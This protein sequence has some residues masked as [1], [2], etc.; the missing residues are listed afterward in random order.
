MSVRREK[1]RAET[2]QVSLFP[3]LAVLLCTMGILIMLL[4]L[5]GQ[6]T[7]ERRELAGQASENAPE[8]KSAWEERLFDFPQTTDSTPEDRTEKETTPYERADETE[9][10]ISVPSPVAAGQESTEKPTAEEQRYRETR[11]AF[12]DLDI[13]GLR[14]EVE[15]AV[16]FR[17]ELQQVYDR[18][19]ESLKAAR[20]TLSQ[21]EAQIARQVEHLAD[22]EN[23]LRAL[24]EENTGDTE[25]TN[26]AIEEKKSAIAALN[27]E[28][29]E[30]KKKVERQ[31]ENRSY[32]ILPYKGK[33]GTFRRPIYVECSAAGVT[34][35]PENFFF[36]MDDL[37]L[38]KFPGNPF[39]TGL[40]TARQ[41]YIET[42]QGSEE[43][44]PYPLLIVRP[45]GSES[46]YAARGALASWGGEC[47]YE[48]IEEDAA[49]EY[50]AASPELAR[51]VQ[52][53]VVVARARM[54][55]TLAILHQQM[56]MER[57]RA[58]VSGSGGGS[59][60]GLNGTG[61]T[62]GLGSGFGSGNGSGGLADQLGPYARL[63]SGSTEE[64]ISIETFGGTAAR[65]N[66]GTDGNAASS[67]IPGVGGD[68]GNEITAAYNGNFAPSAGTSNAV[69]PPAPSGSDSLA[70]ELT[71]EAAGNFAMSLPDTSGYGIGTGEFSGTSGDSTTA[72]ETSA[73]GNAAVQAVQGD[74]AIQ[75]SAQIQGGMPAGSAVLTA[76]SDVVPVTRDTSATGEI[77]PSLTAQMAT[78]RETTEDASGEKSEAIDPS[79]TVG[80]TAY[81]Q[82]DLEKMKSKGLTE[83]KPENRPDHESVKSAPISEKAFNLNEQ[84]HKKTEVA[85]ERP[86]AVECYP[87]KIVF[88]KQN[89]VTRQ[90]EIA[91]ADGC[92]NEILRTIIACVQSW[93]VAG[94]NRYWTPWISASITPGAEQSYQRLATLMTSQKVKI[95]PASQP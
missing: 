52:D 67:E 60:G 15:S 26:A 81:Y 58:L 76:A 89:G 3:F 83:Q 91:W 65:G 87:D 84:L 23:Q 46:Y 24:T 41:Y 45:D 34:L 56:E 95:Q 93:K 94:R 77:P 17:G 19:G 33:N 38:G 62:G 8:E 75:G 85:V 22:L 37:I 54:A 47:G 69:P 50:P 73:P 2:A 63:S 78:P 70:G 92:E 88:P 55:G 51:K 72:L 71:G 29:E 20:Q 5:I 44:E 61:G 66:T 9:P 36:P 90:I 16:W 11:Q 18:T 35:M 27:A 43:D 10:A 12:G 13:D 39:D 86:I 7:A 74:T 64:P 57:Q 80:N 21:T 1:Q 59:G 30:L 25:T 14:S 6:N 53:Q 48:F 79:V 68:D 82:S 49:I 40:R 4:V 32:A 28:I 42:G 31:G